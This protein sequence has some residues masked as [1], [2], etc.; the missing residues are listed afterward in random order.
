[1]SGLLTEP[2]PEA[3]GEAG[4]SG[5]PLLVAEHLRVEYHVGGRG[6][7]LAVDDVTL[8]AA[9]GEM[10]GVVGESGSGKTTVARCLVGLQAPDTGTILLSG[11]PLG[12]RRSAEQRR[13]VQLVFQDPYNSLNPR[14]RIGTVLRQLLAA[15]RLARG[16]AADVRSR[17][18]MGLVGLPADSLASYPSAFSGGQRQRIAI[19]RALAVEPAVLVADE[20]ISALDVSVQA[21]ILG[22]FADLRDRLGIGVVMISHNL[23]AV[24]HVCDRVAVMYLGRV[25]EQGTRDEV[26]H[27]PRHPYTSCPARRRAPRP[28]GSRTRG[29]PPR[30]RAAQPDGA[31][32]RLRV[33]PALPSRRGALRRRASGAAAGG[34]GRESRGRVPL[35][36]GAPMTDEDLPQ[37]SL[38]AAR[39]RP[40]LLDQP[41][42]TA[43]EYATIE[44]AY[45]QL[46]GT[47]ADL[48]VVQ[49]EAILAL[50]ATARGLGRPHRRCLNL[51]TGPYGGLFGEWLAAGGAEVR[52]LAVPFDRAVRPE[53]VE[54]ALGEMGRVDV[55]SLVH[56]EAATGVV[57]DLPAIAALARRA[58]AL[59][60]V[61][62]VASVGA[63][64][65]EVD[66]CGLDLVVLGAHKAL[67]GPSG[68]TGVVVG[69]RA[70]QA[71]ADADAPLRSSSLSLLDWRERW[72][73]AGRVALPLIPNHLETRALGEAIARVA[74]EGG[75]ASVVTRHRAA[76]AAARA[77]LAPLG[78][79][80]WVAETG[81]AAS[82]ATLVQAPQGGSAALLAG[83]VPDPPGSVPALVAAPGSLAADALRIDH[84]GRRAALGEV[85]VALSALADGMRAMG[86]RPDLGASLA[87]A[88]TAW[89]GSSAASAPGSSR[90]ARD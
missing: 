42:V 82:V 72:L 70:W 68:A 30:R 46:L 90:A 86:E 69:P 78:L 87:A 54:A 39:P 61:D 44:D 6:R 66:R 9:A 47:T 2:P 81:E 40:V 75:L 1:M 3:A 20:P 5:R 19:A 49:G 62:A 55:V 12:A 63:E 80:P 38:G 8:W 14:L 17:E 60:V 83:V 79:S 67:A 33:P 16:A 58:E 13:A 4:L 21:T 85:L 50:E 43:A 84:T 76:A 28:T 35:P 31:T 36:G 41:P 56:A 51:V 15:H 10:L 24:R 77:G 65:L 29:D 23:A 74:R 57:N 32:G 27:D 26:F 18:L 73:G 37:V 89:E 59:V 53:Q 34:A 22:L 64:P 11:V 71:L 88:C 45:R 25:V 52:D 7:L 48:V